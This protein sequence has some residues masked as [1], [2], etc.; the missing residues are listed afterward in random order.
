MDTVRVGGVEVEY[1]GVI[2]TRISGIEILQWKRG[3]DE[4]DPI[5]HKVDAKAGDNNKAVVKATLNGEPVVFEQL[6]VQARTGSQNRARSPPRSGAR[7]RR[8]R[9]RS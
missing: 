9:P 1:E 7:Y 6:S 5:V 4:G 2:Q 8:P 3:K